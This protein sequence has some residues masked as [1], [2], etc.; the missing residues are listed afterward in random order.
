[1]LSEN[2]YVDL[3]E[4]QIHPMKKI[5]TLILVIITLVACTKS[6]IKKNGCAKPPLTGNICLPNIFSPNGDGINDVLYVRQS[7]GFPQIDTLEF[8]ILDGTG[9][10][11][12]YSSDPA[13]G[14]DGTYNGK[15]KSGV[16]SCEI[17]A[18]LTNGETIEF[19]GTV[20]C[21][22]KTADEYVINDCTECRF[23]SQFNGQGNFDVNLPTY[24]SAGICE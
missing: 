23:D 21:L 11:L 18:T 20:T 6:T 17:E 8:K 13:V 4:Q 12:F 10:Y 7:P 3:F 1:L 5:C 16:Y 9:A 2:T 24:E 15:K 14:W 19:T 22:A